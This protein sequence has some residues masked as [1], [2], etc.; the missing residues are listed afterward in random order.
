MGVLIALILCTLRSALHTPISVLATSTLLTMV[1]GLQSSRLSIRMRNRL[2]F[3][4]QNRLTSCR[5]TGQSS[6]SSTR[7]SSRPSNGGRRSKTAGLGQSKQPNTHDKTQRVSFQYC[8]MGS[9]GFLIIQL[10]TIGTVFI[11]LLA[12]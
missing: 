10:H 9:L 1:T 4:R 11:H 3:K 6:R 8:A 12:F 5:F 7:R 2:P